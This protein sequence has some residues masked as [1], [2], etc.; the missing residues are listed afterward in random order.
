MS[1]TTPA[2]APGDRRVREAR[3]VGASPARYRCAHFDAIAGEHWNCSAARRTEPA[4]LHNQ[5]GNSPPAGRC[6]RGVGVGHEDLR[7]VE[8]RRSAQ[9]SALDQVAPS[10]TRRASSATPASATCF[11][12]VP[13]ASVQRTPPAVAVRGWSIS[14]RSLR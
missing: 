4:V 7:V 11:R 6:Q 12:W 1:S 3:S 10:A 8:D 5:P 9:V 13:T 2:S 14:S